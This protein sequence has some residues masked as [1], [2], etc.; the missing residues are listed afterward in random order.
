MAQP[1]FVVFLMI[2][3]SCYYYYCLFYF[4]FLP[5]LLLF[6]MNEWLLHSRQSSFGGG[7]CHCIL[8][9]RFSP[10]LLSLKNKTESQG[11]NKKGR[12]RFLTCVVFFSLFPTRKILSRRSLDRE[13]GNEESSSSPSPTFLSYFFSLFNNKSVDC[14]IPLYE[15]NTHTQKAKRGE[16]G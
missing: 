1:R 13:V 10:V 3:S 2:S 14:F 12:E 6:R 4:I 16:S 7:A 15:Q 9:F 8:E 5:K 11:T